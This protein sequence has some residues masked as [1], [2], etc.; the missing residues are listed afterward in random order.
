MY[1]VTGSVSFTF[2]GSVAGMLKP[3]DLA[4][5]CGANAGDISA[6]L[7]ERGAEVIAFDPEPWA[8]APFAQARP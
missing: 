3:G 5:D 2:F 4:I 8:V 7:L 6:R 1:K